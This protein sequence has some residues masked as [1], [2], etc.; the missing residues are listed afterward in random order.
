MNARLSMKRVDGISLVEFADERNQSPSV[1]GASSAST[2][3]I[4]PDM[5][6]RRAFEVREASGRTPAGATLWVGIE[7]KEFGYLTVGRRQWDMLETNDC[8]PGWHCSFKSAWLTWWN[9]CVTLRSAVLLA[10]RSAVWPFS[11]GK[12]GM[13]AVHEAESRMVSVHETEAS[14]P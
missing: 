14:T 10:T 1:S 3:F 5:L 9:L 11:C 7:L 6:H 12:K 8:N 4:R 2:P 13:I